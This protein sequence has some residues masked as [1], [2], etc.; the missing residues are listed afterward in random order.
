M[1]KASR[2]SRV[3]WAPQTQ[4]ITDRN[5]CPAVDFVGRLEQAEYDFLQVV[6]L[7]GS[8][9]E[10]LSFLKDNGGLKRASSTA[11]G[12]RLR[13]HAGGN[14]RLDSASIRA[15]QRRSATEFE[16]L[17]YDI[18]PGPELWVAGR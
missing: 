3:H 2:L 6:Q 15:I 5:G 17:G 8:P 14:S 12:E 7:L 13:E 9:S 16:A 1:K 18:E 11:F 4:F 10:L